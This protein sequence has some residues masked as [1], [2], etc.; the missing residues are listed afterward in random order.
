MTVVGSS[1]QDILQLIAKFAQIKV[2]LDEYPVATNEANYQ[3]Q[4]F[5]LPTV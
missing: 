5:M 1:A 3:R 4:Y 2:A